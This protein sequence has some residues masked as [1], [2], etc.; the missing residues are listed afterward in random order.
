M[1]GIKTKLIKY[2]R[3]VETRFT[4]GKLSNDVA[5][6]QLMEHFIADEY[7]HRAKVSKSDLGYGWIHYGLVRTIKPSRILCV[8]SRYGFIPAILAQACKDNGRGHVDFV[9]P[10]YGPEDT[11]HWTGVGHWRNQEGNKSFYR[12]RLESWIT[13]YLME[14]LEFAK[15][16]KK[17]YEYIYIDGDHSY[18]G[19]SLDYKL[20]YKRLK[21]YG[22]M[23]FHD[24]DV[25]G[26]LSEGTYGTWKLWEKIK[27]NNSF[28]IPFKGS[29][30]GFIQKVKDGD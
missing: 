18:E 16:N 21:K 29:G 15:K 7:G 30:L 24:I 25:K 11:N 4:K 12:F 3:E 22:F 23:A 1:F 10:G 26:K 6:R 8:G 27:N 5:I 17:R 14:S 20:F 9:D 19:V 2:A 28:E 13:L